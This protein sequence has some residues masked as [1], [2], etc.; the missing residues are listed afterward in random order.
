MK[1]VR[2]WLS[3]NLDVVALPLFRSDR[4]ASTTRVEEALRQI[5]CKNHRHYY[6]V[7]VPFW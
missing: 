1:C 3:K 4:E 7:L 5:K 2:E 6:A